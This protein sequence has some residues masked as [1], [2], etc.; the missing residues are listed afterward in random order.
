MRLTLSSKLSLL[1]LASLAGVL[2]PALVITYFYVGE[3]SLRA[4]RQDF[5]SAIQLAE[6]NIN[7]GFIHLNSSKVSSV[8]RGRETLRRA[9]RSFASLCARLEKEKDPAALQL[10][11]QLQKAQEAEYRAEGIL[12]GFLQELPGLRPGL[13][14]IKGRTLEEIL[15]LLHPAGDFAIYRLPERGLTFLYFLPAADSVI[16]SS[17]SMQALEDE[18]DET[19]MTLILGIERKFSSMS[20]HEGSFAALLDSGGGILAGRGVFGR[21]ELDALKPLLAE[22]LAGGRAEAVFPIR[23]GQGR[24]EELLAVAGYSK[25]FGWFTVLAAPLREISSPSEALLARLILQ[26]LSLALLSLMA[27]FL[28][29]RRVLSPLRLVLQKIALL[30]GTDFSAPDA[31]SS[32]IRDL[33]LKRK[34]EVGDLARAFASMGERLNLNIRALVEAS[35]ARDRMQGELNA[36]R[37]IQLG[38]LSPPEQAPRGPELDSHA[39]LEPARETGGDLYDFFTTPDGRYAFII[40]DVSGKGVPAALFMAVTVTLARSVLNSGSPPGEAMNRIN[41]LLEAHNPSTMFVTLFLALYD[42][43]SGRL[44][45]ANGGHNPPYLAGGALPV[46]PLEGN[47]GPFVGVMPGLQYSSFTHTLSRGELCLL[48]TDG[49]TEA[50]NEKEELYGEERL[51]LLLREKRACSPQKLLADIF[52]DIKS[53]RGEAPPF[54]DITMLAFARR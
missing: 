52:E 21:N 26:S 19:T 7:S 49:V 24:E 23:R 20:L 12:V 40:G 32:L 50:V 11:L 17:I 31:A 51:L 22:A 39:L 38:I 29:L 27:G 18:V 13:T 36:A 48:Y 25:P 47:S 42:P 5:S 46:R 30:P 41:E 15:D 35:G 44:E 16:F 6:E 54:D 8:V 14:D 1:L 53:F 2:V 10:L 45:Y 3:T 34:D 4:D 9:A 37:D 33:P 28:L 43:R